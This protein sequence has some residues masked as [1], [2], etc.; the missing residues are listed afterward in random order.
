MPHK[1]YFSAFVAC[2]RSM[3][4][5]LAIVPQLHCIEHKHTRFDH[6]CATCL[7]RTK[8]CVKCLKLRFDCNCSCPQ[9]LTRGF[10][11]DTPELWRRPSIRAIPVLSVSLTVDPMNYLPRM[12]VS[13]DHPIERILIKIGNADP[14]AINHMV[15]SVKHAQKRNPRFLHNN[16][17][18][19]IEKQNP[20][21][22]NGMN[23]GLRY[24]LDSP[25]K[26]T[27]ALIVNSD[28]EFKSKT[29]RYFASNMRR[30][31]ANEPATFGIGFMN[32]HASATWSAFAPTKRLA[33][34]IGLFDENFYPAY[35]ED[36]DY[37]YLLLLSGFKVAMFPDA[38][39]AHGPIEHGENNYIS[40]TT[41][42]I[43]SVRHKYANT[44]NLERLG[45]VSSL[46]SLIAR[47]IRSNLQYYALKWGYMPEYPCL[48]VDSLTTRV[49]CSIDW[50]LPFNSSNFDLRTWRLGDCR[51][52][53]IQSGNRD[54]EEAL[55]AD[56]LASS[57]LSLKSF[58]SAA[59]GSFCNLY[60]H[61][62]WITSSHMSEANEVFMGG[63][64]LTEAMHNPRRCYIGS[65]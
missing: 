64:A 22:A 1:F 18:L 32:L 34:H 24:I 60:E 46:E 55:V 14:V 63:V 29:L 54:L 8:D 56:E 26:N 28:I 53:W 30:H 21:A 36:I 10:S 59:H 43:R 52:R 58:H 51:R 15:S 6:D 57:E 27:W 25:S 5:V 16:L 23:M 48:S 11:N 33:Q 38:L 3:R 65:K 20:G 61:D 31:I 50:T 2:L 45:V 19:H 62:P 40:G 12:L 7:N 35:M 42:T 44:S 37:A 9:H 17:R 4:Y 39:V 49:N 41:F 47:G 13:I